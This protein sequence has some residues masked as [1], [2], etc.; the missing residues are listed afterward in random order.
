M[1]EQ[2]TDGQGQGIASSSIQGK[3][4]LDE[5]RQQAK[6]NRLEGLRRLGHE[7]LAAQHWTEAE[8]AFLA[9]LD[10]APQDQDALQ[11][12]ALALDRS[13]Q[14]EALYE[15]ALIMLEIS[16]NSAHGLA[17]KARAL[18]KLGRLSEATIANDQ[19]LLLDT[20][21]GLA[22]INRSG[23]QLLLGKLPEA[24]RSSRRAVE[25]APNDSRA[26]AN[27]GVALTNYSRL[28]EAL[29]A[30]DYSLTL[31]PGQLFA[32]QMKG[33]ILSRIGR[34][35]D[36]LQVVNQTLALAPNDLTALNQGMQALRSLEMYDR[37]KEVA[38]HLIEMTPENAA[39]W[40]NYMRSLRG[41]GQFAEAN[42]ALDHLLTMDGSNIRFWTLKADTLYRL[43]R[44]REAVSVAE[45]AKRLSP[46]YPPVLRIHEKALKLM[47]QRK[48][49]KK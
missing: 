23:L 6:Q 21:L 12:M 49:K 44:Y 38:Q 45:R 16:P 18:Q 27:Q 28:G 33:E 1:D 20:N 15:T 5:Q 43:E 9:L 11:G 42:E 30:F 8:E 36:L 39:A 26:W 17:Y 46:D 48:E 25:L 13:N 47:Y 31:D 19:A 41:L 32:L 29:E 7:Q 22:W 2:K 34:M 10:Y 3:I 14:F 37:L 40:E 4:V 24:L 35:N